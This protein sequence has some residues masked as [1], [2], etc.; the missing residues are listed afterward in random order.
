[1]AVQKIRTDMSEA[2][3]RKLVAQIAAS[4][5]RNTASAQTVKDSAAGSAASAAAR[6]LADPVDVGPSASSSLIAKGGK[7]AADTSRYAEAQ[8]AIFQGGIDS[9]LAAGNQYYDDAARTA[10][11]IN[12]ELVE[13]DKALAEQEAARIAAQRGYG[14]GDDSLFIPETEGPGGGLLDQP[15]DTD[16]WEIPY[17]VPAEGVIA[18]DPDLQEAATIAD[19]LVEEMYFKGAAFGGA[20]GQAFSYLVN[21]FGLTDDQ[22]RAV[23]AD[24][25]A[26]WGP[27]WDQDPRNVVGGSQLGAPDGGFYGQINPG[28]RPADPRALT[29]RELERRSRYGG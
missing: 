3:R 25:E 19:A 23:M 9:D 18:T 5:T 20:I 15:D 26:V 16:R 24:L 6:V 12:S 4:G 10:G 17:I 14:D 11:A 21:G 1:M 22:A 28:P 29:P 8:R 13:Y 27:Q 2:E 7:A